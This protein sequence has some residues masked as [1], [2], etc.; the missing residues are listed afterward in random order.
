MTA[1]QELLKAQKEAMNVEELLNWRSWMPYLTPIGCAYVK[2][3][4][5]R[6]YKDARGYYYYR[7]VN[8]S[9]LHRNK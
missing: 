6:Y 5:R 7:A 1:T 4:P 8:E 3:E 2:G 9:E